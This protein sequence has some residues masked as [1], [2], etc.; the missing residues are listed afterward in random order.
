MNKY[1][2]RLLIDYKNI[3]DLKYKDIKTNIFKRIYIIYLESI[4]DSS[5]INDFILKNLTNP[6]AK[7]DLNSS[8]PGP[9]TIKIN[10]YNDIKKYL[11]NGF[12]IVLYL[13]TILAI[14]VKAPLSRSIPTSSREPTLYGPED[15]FCENYQT[16]LGLI[17]RRIKSSSLETKELTIGKRS[18]TLV[19]VCYINDII[20]KK[21]L[22]T[23]ID[24]LNK[25]DT[26]S[27][28]DVGIIV[29][30]LEEESKSVFPTIRRTERPDVVASSLLEGKIVILVDTSP[31]A[32][33]L[34]TFLGDFINPISDNYVKSPNVA[35]LKLL[36]LFCF[37][38]AIIMPSLFVAVTNY[39]QETI[40]ANLLI[41][42]SI[43]QSSVP[44]PATI[45]LLILII[46]CDILR[47]SD[48]RFPSNFGS[49]ISILGAL[50]IGEAAVNAGI[51]SPIM[52]II[53]SLTYICSLIFNDLEI[54]NAIRYY[55]YLFLFLGAFLGL[56]GIFIASTFLLINLVSLKS[57]GSPYLF[58]L[59]PFDK[60]YFFKTILKKKEVNNTQRSA[61][62]SENDLTK[63]ENK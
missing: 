63:G 40:P 26:D 19:G 37:I 42:F 27:I 49:T 21:N 55:R 9:N 10:N 43:Q 22:N 12:A 4:C 32:I 13:N 1:L 59:A 60:N 31:F 7:P 48:L 23:V 62:L 38:L 45:E 20:K 33:I 28:L 52:I 17:K 34:P 58:P 50:I 18:S 53:T 15:A 56:Y 41:N 46:I 3:P 2:K 11:H 54:N 36:R 29:N 51:V 57:I 5:K 16:N 39:N 6:L 24:K 35:F 44:F 30:Y 61:L 47:E 14:E 8:I 25:I